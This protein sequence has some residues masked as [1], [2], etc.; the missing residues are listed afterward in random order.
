MAFQ[1]SALKKTTGGY[2]KK[3]RV[4]EKLYQEEWLEILFD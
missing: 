4:K 3:L 2:R 1:I